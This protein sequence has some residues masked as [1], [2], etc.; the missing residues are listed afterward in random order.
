MRESRFK[1]LS[2]SSGGAMS[3]PPIPLPPTPPPPPPPPHQESVI[4]YSAK[5]I[6]LAISFFQQGEDLSQPVVLKK[7]LLATHEENKKTNKFNECF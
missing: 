2:S 3:L 4:F 7:D 6:G 1:E 5:H